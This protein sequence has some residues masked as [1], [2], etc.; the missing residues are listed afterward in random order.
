VLSRALR[1]ADA[2]W[3]S[4]ERDPARLR[5]AL[6]QTLSAEPLAA[7]DYAEVVDPES[8]RPGLALAVMAVRIG[9]TRL[10]D[11]HPLGTPFRP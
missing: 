8:F 2:A 11:N 3:R 10:I 7:V 1:A 9:T 6:H 4:G 5:S